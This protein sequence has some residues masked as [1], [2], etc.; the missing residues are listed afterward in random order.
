MV[1]NKSNIKYARDFLLKKIIDPD[2]RAYA[3]TTLVKYEERTVTN[4]CTVEKH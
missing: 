4:F 3:H 2:I 1:Q